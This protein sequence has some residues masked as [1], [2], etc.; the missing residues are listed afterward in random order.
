MG[1]Y[2][3]S[4]SDRCWRD[5]IISK[6]HNRNSKECQA[7]QGLITTHN[8]LFE[9]TDTLK[10]ENLQLTV[11]NEQLR[12]GSAD[13][14]GKN[15]RGNGGEKV[16]ALEMKLFRLQEEL[17]ELHRRKGE[18]AQQLIDM[19]NLLTVKEK[20]M[21]SKDAKLSEFE[22]NLKASLENENTLVQT[23]QELE[24]TNQMLKDEHQALQLAYTRS[25]EDYRNTLDINRKIKEE[26]A[27]LIDRWMKLKA[28][29]ADQMN[30][31]NENFLRKK[32]QKDNVEL[33]QDPLAF[34]LIHPSSS[35]E[36]M[37]KFT[38]PT[39]ILTKLDTHEGEV[40]AVKWGPR[41][42]KF[43]SGGSDRKVKLWE[44]V[45]DSIELRGVLRGSNAAITS[46]DFNA[47]ED[48]LLA[49]SNDFA[50]RV[51][52]TSDERLR[53]T[54]TGHS[55]R[56][57]AAKFLG[58]SSKVVS[59]SHDRTIKM[60]DLRNLACILFQ[61]TYLLLLNNYYLFTV[62][63]M[64]TIFTGSSCNDVV[65]DRPGTMIISGHF[66][67]RIRLWDSRRESMANEIALQGKVTSLDISPGT[68]F[69]FIVEV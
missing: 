6:L 53:H 42:R 7:Y 14:Q 60:W 65:T 1:T 18:N 29:D 11:Q 26:N 37:L 62:L 46:V 5:V 52:T 63:G 40:L 25:Q 8:K 50:S 43:A 66:D 24:A 28:R 13:M 39:R 4:I 9:V 59:G 22:I 48:L 69:E 21:M 56:V 68:V 2:R 16:M 10:H 67:K 64:R 57:L 33:T 30:E 35:P 51:W 44:V 27:E 41:G 36:N 38:L 49:T 17:T 15:E 61:L 55:G 31:E 45:K 34:D 32:S 3:C 54:L 23:V 47:D 58:D 20:E 19:R 12:M